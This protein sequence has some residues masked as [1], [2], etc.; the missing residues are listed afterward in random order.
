MGMGRRDR[1]DVKNKIKTFSTSLKVVNRLFICHVARKFVVA[2]FQL[3]G[4][5][6]HEVDSSFP[7]NMEF[8][9]ELSLQ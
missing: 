6:R 2:F 7:I 5:T 4:Y 1:N 8:L 3:L 9:E